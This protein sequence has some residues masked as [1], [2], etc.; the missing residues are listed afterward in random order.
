MKS[1]AASLLIALAFSSTAGATVLSNFLTFD[2]PSGV[3][4]FPPV[5]AGGE[6]KLQ[7]DSLSRLIDTGPAGI[8]AGDSIFGVLTL[9]EVLASGRPSVPVGL[10]SQVAI[11]YAGT[12]VAGPGGALGIVANPALLSATCGAVCAG[13]GINAGSIGVFLSTTTPDTNPASDPLNWDALGANNVTANFNNLNGNGAWSWEMTAGLNSPSDFFQFSGDPL[14][15][16]TNRA[17]LTITSTAF[18]PVTWL[19][20]DVLDFGLGTH[21][22][23]LSLDVATTNPASI[24][25]QGRG[26]TFRDQ[27]SFFVNPTIAQIPEPGTLALLSLGLLGLAFRSRN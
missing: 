1:K 15:G 21:L 8:S 3:G 19:D 24:P 22:V 12:Y 25:E 6:D 18:P 16:G 7:D 27:S 26:W 20:V 10:N 23:D 13:A 9:S 17:G 14:L 4:G 5:Q 11:L 2:G